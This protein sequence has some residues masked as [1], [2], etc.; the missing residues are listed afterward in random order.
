MADSLYNACKQHHVFSRLDSQ[1]AEVNNYWDLFWYHWWQMLES[2]DIIPN[3]WAMMKGCIKSISTNSW[4]ANPFK[5][6]GRHSIKGDFLGP[7]LVSPDSSSKMCFKLK[8]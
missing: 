3:F 7:G 5:F 4:A 8:A 2:N 1:L 6:Q